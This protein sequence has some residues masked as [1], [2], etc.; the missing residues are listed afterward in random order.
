M[1]KSDVEPKAA[2]G[3]G[4]G[5]LFP[6]QEV[7]L[8]A[9]GEPAQ[10]YS[11]LKRWDEANRERPGGPISKTARE[12]MASS[13]PKLSSAVHGSTRQTGG[14]DLEA[15]EKWWSVLSQRMPPNDFGAFVSRLKSHARSRQEEAD[16]NQRFAATSARLREKPAG[17]ELH[18]AKR[19]ESSARWLRHS[20]ENAAILD[21]L[22]EAAA[23]YFNDRYT[24]NQLTE[25]SQSIEQFRLANLIRPSADSPLEALKLTVGDADFKAFAAYASEKFESLGAL[26]LEFGVNSG[27]ILHRALI[28]QFGLSAEDA[29]KARSKIEDIVTSIR[30]DPNPPLILPDS[31]PAYSYE[32]R[33]DGG[34]VKYLRDNWEPYIRA[35][36]MNRPDL[37]RID[38]P[39]YQALRNWLKNPTNVLPEELYLPTISEHTDRMLALRGL[40]DLSGREAAKL[41][42]AAVRRAQKEPA[43][44]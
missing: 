22:A 26:M 3:L 25:L 1:A 35:G 31:P 11:L 18:D 36:I 41:A 34:I 13:L 10:V 16:R 30:S 5:K 40:G 15:Y 42:S 7:D 28:I 19:P 9:L 33:M 24:A 21:Q 17:A 32:P 12:V 38:P 39:A 44:E 6:P 37:N 14:V 23:A 8:E 29:E 4:S 27:D 2:L 20:K 43:P